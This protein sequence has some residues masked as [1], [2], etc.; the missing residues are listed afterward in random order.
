MLRDITHREKTLAVVTI[1]IVLLALLYNFI[2]EP[3]ARR[4][5]TLDKEMRDKEELLTKHSRILR[6]KRE[7][8]ELQ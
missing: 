1:T 3:L 8:E 2:M 5:N 6:S 7:I 4:W